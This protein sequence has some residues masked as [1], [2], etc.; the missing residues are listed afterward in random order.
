MGTCPFVWGARPAFCDRVSFCCF[1]RWVRQ[2]R[3]AWEVSSFRSLYYESCYEHCLFYQL[4]GYDSSGYDYCSWCSSAPFQFLS[5]LPIGSSFV[6]RSARLSQLP[7][8]L[9]LH[10]SVGSERSF[11][12]DS[13]WGTKESPSASHSWLVSYDWCT[14]LSI[15]GRPCW[16]SLAS[17]SIATS[18]KTIASTTSTTTAAFL[19]DWYIKRKI[20]T[21]QIL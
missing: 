17:T 6:S 9:F 1:D 18:T 3:C 5:F 13:Y 7:S 14:R 2:R 8:P 15:A 20:F 10:Y 11:P 4:S 16:N 12:P 19:I 21:L